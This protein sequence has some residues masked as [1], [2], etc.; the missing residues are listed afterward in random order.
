MQDHTLGHAQTTLLPS[1]WHSQVYAFWEHIRQILQR[2]RRLRRKY[3]L[4]LRPKPHFNKVFV[5]ACWEVNQS[6]D[7]APQ[8]GKPARSHVMGDQRV[9]EW[10][11]LLLIMRSSVI[12]MLAL[13]LLIVDTWKPVRIR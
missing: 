7:S 4:M 10:L 1:N 12:R 8:T 2:K 3:A 9:P 11:K 6:V 13:K 5:L